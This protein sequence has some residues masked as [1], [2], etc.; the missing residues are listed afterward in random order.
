MANT[1]TNIMDK[2][3]AASV[4]T[5]RETAIMPRLINT[6]YSEDA[7]KQG[8]TIDVP[9][10]TAMGT[11]DVTPSNT[12]PASTAVIPGLVQIPLS[13]WKQND[14]FSLSDKEMAEIDRNAH[15]LPQT[16]T[17]S[18]RALTNLVNVDILDEYKGIYGY[19]GTAG[20]TPFQSSV[21]A[22]TQAK[23]ILNDQNCPTDSRRFVMD[24]TAEAEALALSQFADMEKTG[25]NGVKIEGEIG[26]KYGFNMFYD[27]A[28]PTH[29]AGTGA[30]MQTAAAGAVAATSIAIDTGTGTLVV[31]DIITFAGHNQTYVIDTAVADVSSATI[32]FAPPLV[33]A[34]ADNAAITLKA[35]HTV[36][37][38]FHRDAFAYASRPLMDSGGVDG[39]NMSQLSD[40]VTGLT[41]RLEVSRQHKQTAW[42][43]DILWG[44][45]LVRPDLACRV[46]G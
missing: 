42:E 9:I 13:N 29:T 43:F 28:I 39:V 17:E 7:K 20:T 24:S 22:A 2:I 5:L 23:K 6:S 10:P 4:A 45:K 34:V 33:E 38:A 27:D 30:N 18:V 37:L 3:L 41:L 40:P 8:D 35:S 32:S 44:A 16:V 46:A 11:R 25:M 21:T 14:P 15:F 31:G 36:N 26:R 19:T 12:P 1:L